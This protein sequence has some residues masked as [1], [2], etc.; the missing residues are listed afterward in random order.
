VPRA[1]VAAAQW[2]SVSAFNYT[3]VSRA[4]GKFGN[5]LCDGKKVKN[6]RGGQVLAG[7]FSPYRVDGH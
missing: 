1:A 6:L 5:N 7:F 3:R 4:A 2:K